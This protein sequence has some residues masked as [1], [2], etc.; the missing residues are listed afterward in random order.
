MGILRKYLCLVLPI[1]FFANYASADTCENDPY[2]CTPAKLCSKTTEK[3]NNVL[4]WISSEEDKHLKVARKINLNCG[5]KDAMSSC[6]K[7]ASE[8]SILE[9]CEVAAMEEV[10]AINWNEIN[11]Q[12]VKLAK[13]FG[14]DCGVKEAQGIN[15]VDKTSTNKSLSQCDL[16]PAACVSEELCEKATYGVVGNKNWT[17]PKVFAD[18][19][20]EAKQRGLTCGVKSTSIDKTCSQDVLNCTPAELCE[21][22]T[23]NI[24][25]ITGWK[26]GSY[27]KFVDEA[28]RRNIS[29]GVN[30]DKKSS[31]SNKTTLIRKKVNTSKARC[32]ADLKGCTD[33]DLCMTATFKVASMPKNWK[34]GSYKKFV[35]EAKRRNI[36]CGVKSANNDQVKADEI[37]INNSLQSDG[38]S[39][40]MN[41]PSA[42]KP[43]ELCEKATY[44][45]FPN[46][47]W[48]TPQIF[49]E[50]VKEAKQRGLNCGVGVS[51]SS[52][53]SN[54]LNSENIKCDDNPY[55]C[56]KEK[57]C[58]KAVS[59]NDEVVTWNRHGSNKI[60]ATAAIRR[61]LDCKATYPMNCTHKYGDGRPDQCSDVELCQ[62][63]ID[64]DDENLAKWNSTNRMGFVFEAKK[65]NLHC[66]TNIADEKHLKLV[67]KNKILDA[68]F[69]A[70]FPIKNHDEIFRNCYENFETNIQNAELKSDKCSDIE[71]CSLTTF[72]SNNRIIWIP[73]PYVEYKIKNLAKERKLNCAVG[74]NWID[75]YDKR[76]FRFSVTYKGCF[77][78]TENIRISNHNGVSKIYYLEKDGETPMEFEGNIYK[79]TAL[80]FHFEDI[81]TG[82]LFQFYRL[83]GPPNAYN[84]DPYYSAIGSSIV[85]TDKIYLNYKMQQ[86]GERNGVIIIGGG[87]VTRLSFFECPHM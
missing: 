30:L 16:N 49:K 80:Q 6:Q 24:N 64:Y 11:P 38:L 73:N 70:S 58:E 13:S 22:A 85:K 2:A 48:T 42:C 83:V 86:K 65:R 9:L 40:D 66:G 68:N 71:V 1:V 84:D 50:Y 47:K 7:D 67:N 35:D 33:Y 23:Y 53:N 18:F 59:M 43:E 20:K 79:H 52:E 72:V 41:N 62:R 10:S 37:N 44:G 8:C 46:Q 81:N 29:C 14:L 87:K 21:T 17:T 4:Y 34:L 55:L 31:V 54:R 39:C 25:G 28:K 76:D 19:V 60:Y 45:T 57:L 75:N 3:I 12:H 51:V 61:G 26:L 77:V 15:K 32:E 74:T 5:A 36:S 69:L 56:P 78:D 82:T 27:K 63:A